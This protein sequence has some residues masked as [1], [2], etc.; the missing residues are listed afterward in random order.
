ME[1][2]NLALDPHTR[3]PRNDE[4]SLGLDREVARGMVAAVAYVRKRGDNYIAWTDTTGQY[5]QETR[6]LPDSTTL[7]VYVL[8]TPP[9]ARLFLLT[10]RREA[11]SCRAPPLPT[12]PN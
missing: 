2:E 11:C 10:R 5:R 12:A 8:T 3:T 9:S 4:Y 7:P 6:T 1:P